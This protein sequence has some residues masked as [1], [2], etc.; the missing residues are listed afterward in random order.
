MTS[1]VPVIR[2]AILTEAVQYS[3]AATVEPGA[4][5]VVLA[6]ACPLDGQGA[7]VDVGDYAGQAAKCVENMVITLAEAGASLEDVVATRVLV[8]SP[9]RQDLVAAWD[10]VRDAFGEHEVPSPVMGVT[11]LGYPD[12]LVEI[13]VTAA[14]GD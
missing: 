9:Q 11:V 6:G 13:E 12:Q 2:S 3:Y 5:L 1:A 4:R 7:T 8:A 14:V 10:V